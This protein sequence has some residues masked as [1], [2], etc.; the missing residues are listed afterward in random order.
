MNVNQSDTREEA[1]RVFYVLMLL[2]TVS[3]SFSKQSFCQTYFV[4]ALHHIHNLYTQMLL[5][6]NSYTGVHPELTHEKLPPEVS[7]R[8]KR[9]KQLN[10]S[11]LH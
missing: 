3:H 8:Y 2:I 9:G 4:W 11:N 7:D 10:F 5:S 1:V 6:E